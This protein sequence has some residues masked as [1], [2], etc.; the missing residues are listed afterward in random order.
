VYVVNSN[1]ANVS[2]IDTSTNAVIATVPVGILPQFIV[3]SSSA[4]PP[5]SPPPPPVQVPGKPRDVSGV[6]KKNTFLTQTELF[7]VI[8]WKAPKKGPTPVSYKIF[9]NAQLTDFVAQISAKESLSFTDHNRKKHTS[10]TYY[11]VS[12]DEGD[13]ISEPAVITINPSL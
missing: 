11:I 9:R 1:S 2:V 8:T 7:N 12:I 5:P 3:I 6:Q 4:P 10:Y 13:Q